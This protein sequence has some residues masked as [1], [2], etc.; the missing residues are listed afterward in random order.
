MLSY[1]GKG[2]A[3]KSVMLMQREG[4]CFCIRK[5]MS[6]THIYFSAFLKLEHTFTDSSGCHFVC[7]SNKVPKVYPK[8]N[9]LILT[10]TLLF[11][12]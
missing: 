2:K 3:I 10:N 8:Y 4:Y 5:R 7:M 9:Q 12:F 1:S 6:R 11:S